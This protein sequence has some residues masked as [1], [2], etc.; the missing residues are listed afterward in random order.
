MV[1][2]YKF[3]KRLGERFLLFFLARWLRLDVGIN[4]GGLVF[5]LAGGRLFGFGALWGRITRDFASLY[6]CHG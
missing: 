1:S 3:F 2:S 4:S 6:F 5:G